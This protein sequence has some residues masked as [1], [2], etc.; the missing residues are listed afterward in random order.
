MRFGRRRSSSTLPYRPVLKAVAARNE[1]RVTAFASNWGYDSHE[2][3]WRTLIDRKDIDV[4]DIASPN[5]THR[6]IAIAAAQGR[7]DGH[8]REAARPDGVRSR[9]DGRGRRV[10][11]RA[12]Y[13]LVQLPSRPG[14]HVDQAAARRGDVRTN[15]SL[16]GQ[17]P[18]GLDDLEGSASGRRGALAARRLGR[19]QRRHRRSARAQHRHRVVA[20]RAHLGGQRDDRDVHQGAQ[21]QPDGQGP[22]CR[23]R[24]CERVSVPVRE[25]LARHVRSHTLRARAQGAL[26]ARDQRRACVRI[27]GS[28]RPSPH[29]V[30]RPSRRRQGAR[31]AQR[32]RDRRRSA[33][34]EALVGAWPADRL[35]AHLHPPVRGVRRGRRR[36]ARAWRRRS[37]TAWPPIS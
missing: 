3:D 13:G 27:L 4:I 18:P 32:P 31:L 30:L 33:V 1:D 36:K 5:D 26:H 28:A 25:R 10:G 22:A 29:P 7:Q 19:R 37:A 23:D 20:E 6:E 11:R 34:H 15:L 14:C 24:R 2:T 16:P 9:G 8:V 12:Q 35:R 17:I 21:T